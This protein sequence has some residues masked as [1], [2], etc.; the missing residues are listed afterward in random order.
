MPA[1]TENTSSARAPLTLVFASDTL[2][3]LPC[4][5]ELC[6]TWMRSGGCPY[7][8]KCQFAH[9]V[10]E[11]RAR[12]VRPSNAQPLAA[13]LVLLQSAVCSLPSPEGPPRRIPHTVTGP[14]ALSPRRAREP[15]LAGP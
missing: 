10:N 4:Q 8:H 3:H 5:T 7:G 2:S 9:G 1:G 12:Q 11:L 15:L 14:R 13:G 6:S